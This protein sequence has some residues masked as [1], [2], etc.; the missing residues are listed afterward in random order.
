MTTTCVARVTGQRVIAQS[1]TVVAVTSLS[2]QPLHSPP[3]V[4]AR[5]TATRLLGLTG[6]L[7]WLGCA[8][9]TNSAEP[10][11]AVAAFQQS[12]GQNELALESLTSAVKKEPD[13]YSGLLRL[14]NLKR[15]H[16]R[17]LRSAWDLAE[18]AK[19][20]APKNDMG[21]QQSQCATS[22]AGGGP[23]L[24]ATDILR[25]CTAAI[26]DDPSPAAQLLH[27]RALHYSGD[28]R[29]ADAIYST[30]VKAHPSNDALI[31][32]YIGLLGKTGRIPEAVS[33]QRELLASN[34]QHEQ[35]AK[36]LV[37][38]LF[39][40]ADGHLRQGD[41]DKACEAAKEA[42]GLSQEAPVAK[43]VR[44][45]CGKVPAKNAPGSQNRQ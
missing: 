6:C 21:A 7:L 19:K 10:L 44:Q 24:H 5:H 45:M 29:A 42:F 20:V 12:A 2:Q 8:E 23:R 22:L 35:R 31:A 16:N 39:M 18:R 11:I 33:L 4:L 14:A 34:P 26:A 13:N 27:A 15:D 28:V 25:K 3:K 36:N 17:D 41:G 9:P 30:L 1:A 37:G 32:H 43:R 40:L 38:L